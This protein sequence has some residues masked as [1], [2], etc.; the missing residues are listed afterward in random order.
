MVPRLDVKPG[1]YIKQ[2]FERR[3]TTHFP[4]LLFT[5][6]SLPCFP[7]FPFLRFSLSFLRSLPTS[8]FVSTFPSFPTHSYLKMEKVVYQIFLSISLPSF[9]GTFFL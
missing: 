4:I 6:F 7:F 1:Y 8:T 5:F 2:G 3:D 9:E